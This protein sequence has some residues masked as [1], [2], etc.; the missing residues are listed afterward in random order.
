MSKNDNAYTRAILEDMKDCQSAEDAFKKF[1][2]FLP[3]MPNEA[4]WMVIRALWVNAANYRSIDY[5]KVLFS[6]TRWGRK[7]YLMDNVEYMRLYRFN[8]KVTAYTP[9]INPEGLFPLNLTV[10]RV[11]AE[12]LCD[13]LGSN[14]ILKVMIPKDQ[15]VAYFHDRYE[16]IVPDSTK[17]KIVETIGYEN[18]IRLQSDKVSTH[19]QPVDQDVVHAQG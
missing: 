2:K 4:Y 11:R 1:E 15:I 6:D 8:K 17:I 3:T 14:K 18:A 7:K 5:W 16:I 10:S 12:K 9:D 13:L 19:G